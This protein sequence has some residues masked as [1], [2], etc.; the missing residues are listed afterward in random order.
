MEIKEYWSILVAAGLIEEWENMEAIYKPITGW[1]IYENHP[2]DLD[3]IVIGKH[4][5]SSGKNF[6]IIQLRK[7]GVNL[8]ELEWIKPTE[9]DIGKMCWFWDD[10]FNAIYKH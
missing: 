8:Y 10:E 5:V 4:K 2:N 7:D 1:V 6:A 3:A 9:Q